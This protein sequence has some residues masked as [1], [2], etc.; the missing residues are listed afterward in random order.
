MIYLPSGAEFNGGN[1]EENQELYASQLPEEDERD[2]ERVLRLCL[3]GSGAVGK[4]CIVVR[5]MRNIFEDYYD[6]TIEDSYRKHIR[7]DGQIVTLDILDTAG[8]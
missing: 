4:S 7:V 2:E 3:L 5:F 6:P 8:Q 1:L